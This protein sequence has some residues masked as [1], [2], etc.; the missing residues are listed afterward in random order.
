MNRWMICYKATPP[1]TRLA[2]RWCGGWLPSRSQAG[3]NGQGAPG[4]CG[5]EWSGWTVGYCWLVVLGYCWWLLVIF[6]Y[7]WLFLVVVGDCYSL[8]V[9]VGDCWLSWNGWTGDQ[10]C[11]GK[12]TYSIT[13][14][15]P[16]IEI[17]DN[18]ITTNSFNKLSWVHHLQTW[19]KQTI[20]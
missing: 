14:R 2:P 1:T 16:R 6:G 5:A 12:T 20:K 13:N 7:C 19:Q 17:R 3:S 9:I 11:W 10:E 18:D 4:G 8:L 15:W